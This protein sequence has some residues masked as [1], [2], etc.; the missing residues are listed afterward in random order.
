MPADLLLAVHTNN[1]VER[2]NEELKRGFLDSYRKCSLSE[3][4]H[5]IISQFLPDKY[6]RLIFLSLLLSLDSAVSYINTD[7]Y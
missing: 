5:V 1:G 2:L 3:L 6:Q 4:L 7:S